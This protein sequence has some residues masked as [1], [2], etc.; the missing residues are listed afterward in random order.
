[1]K[2]PGADHFFKELVY[3]Y[4]LV[5]WSDDS[6][7]VG[8]HQLNDISNIIHACKHTCIDGRLLKKF[9]RNGESQLWEHF[10]EINVESDMV[11]TSKI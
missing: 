2:R 9:V 8:F 4:E 1:M 7:P 6:F 3:H 10:I 5:V 11:N